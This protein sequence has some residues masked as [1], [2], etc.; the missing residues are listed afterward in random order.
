[1]VVVGAAGAKSKRVLAAIVSKGAQNGASSAPPALLTTFSSHFF[2]MF[3]SR[4][5]Q[6]SIERLH[7]RSYAL[8]VDILQQE[9]L[10]GKQIMGII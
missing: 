6:A 8:S 1:M 9:T 2:T 10:I 5:D 4:A 3:M 7:D